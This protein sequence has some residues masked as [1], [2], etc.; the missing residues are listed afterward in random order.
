MDYWQFNKM[1][2]E[3]AYCNTWMKLLVSH[4]QYIVYIAHKIGNKFMPEVGSN[5]NPTDSV[6]GNMQ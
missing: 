1:L 5:V 3:F 6:G 2:Y 4:R